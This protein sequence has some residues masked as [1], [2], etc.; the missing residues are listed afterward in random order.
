MSVGGTLF[1]YVG[2]RKEFFRMMV[3]SFILQIWTTKE[4]IFI[5]N[6]ANGCDLFVY[7]MYGGRH[8]KINQ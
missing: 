8:T 2:L 4:N 6:K 1:F 7:C 5:N 3:V